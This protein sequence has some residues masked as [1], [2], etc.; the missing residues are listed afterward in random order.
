MTAHQC[1]RIKL[2]F[3]GEKAK[4]SQNGSSLPLEMFVLRFPPV[5]APY[6]R[7]DLQQLFSTVFKK[8]QTRFLLHNDA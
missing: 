8:P 3:L 2:D 1:V 6:T 7:H 4:E 5:V